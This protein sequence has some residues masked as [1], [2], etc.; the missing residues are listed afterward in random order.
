WKVTQ[1]LFISFLFSDSIGHFSRRAH[2][3]GFLL[4]LCEGKSKEKKI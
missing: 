3:L 2:S 4:L 1:E